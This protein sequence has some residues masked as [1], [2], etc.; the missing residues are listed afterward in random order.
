[1]R[2]KTTRQV[3][4]AKT[5]QKDGGR[6]RGS[7]ASEFEDSVSIWDRIPP[8][9][10]VLGL[11]AVLVVV[12]QGSIWSGVVSQVLLPTPSQVGLET[13]SVVGSIIS[14]GSVWESFL[15]TV[16]E[17]V[18]ALLIATVGGLSFGAITAETAF[19]RTV[20]QPFVIALYV[21]PKIAFAPVLV[22]WLGFDI[23][24]KVVIGAIIAFF[25]LLVDTAAGLKSVDKE[26][27]KLF[28]SLGATRWQAFWLLKV[29]KA[30]PSIFAGLK[31]AAV[32]SVIGAVVGEYLSGGRGLGAAIQIASTQ[33]A[34]DRVFAYV[35]VLS[36]MAYSLYFSIVV[37]EQKLVFWRRGSF[38]GVG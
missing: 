4:V 17:V 14:G 2:S 34:M 5:A 3:M 33:F 27:S 15:V 1:M 16:K 31:T 28:R 18:L 37:C 10:S 38:V 36:A 8:P 11:A 22:A 21:A 7:V 29:R 30:M 26:E 35:I 32:L 24:P 20:L 25:P 12:W 19:G 13:L 23:W 9:I 6:N